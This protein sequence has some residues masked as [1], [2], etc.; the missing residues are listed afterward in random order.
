VPSTVEVLAWTIASLNRKIRTPASS[1]WEKYPRDSQS[2]TMWLD[3]S[4]TSRRTSTPRR[5]AARS[6]STKSWSGMK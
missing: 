3:L 1:S 6:A 5:A 4:G 2:A